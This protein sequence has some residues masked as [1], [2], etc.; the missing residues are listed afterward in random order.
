MP[1]WAQACQI[2][3]WHAS[4]G[5][6]DWPR[7]TRLGPGSRGHVKLSIPDLTGM[8][9]KKFLISEAPHQNLDIDMAGTIRPYVI[10]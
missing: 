10:I 2:A 1:D 9:I 6:S 7:H 4:S 8:S 3:S 5:I